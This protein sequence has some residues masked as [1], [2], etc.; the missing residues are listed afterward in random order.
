MATSHTPTHA[1]G[2]TTV[3]TAGTR[4]RL[5]ATSLRCRKVQVY[6]QAANTGQIYV[7]GSDVA[8]TTHTGLDAAE[9]VTLETERNFLDLYDLWLDSSVN[10]EKVDFYAQK[11]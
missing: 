2:S 4:V 9:S 1:V 5:H 10:G 3:T 11:V 6:A 7:G 8:S